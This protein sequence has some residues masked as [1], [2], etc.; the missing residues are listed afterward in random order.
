M[1]LKGQEEKL[2]VDKIIKKASW[3]GAIKGGERTTQQGYCIKAYYWKGAIWNTLS[4][5]KSWC[6]GT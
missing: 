3:M 4:F 6:V 2:E 5:P 1:Q